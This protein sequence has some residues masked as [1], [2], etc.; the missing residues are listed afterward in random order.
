MKIFGRLLI[1]PILI[2]YIKS[3]EL[4]DR[5]NSLFFIK[6]LPVQRMAGTHRTTTYF[7]EW[8]GRGSSKEVSFCWRPD[9]ARTYFLSKIKT[10]G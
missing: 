7:I 1:S 10:K 2:R 9:V 8:G 4:D 5:D 6:I 3:R